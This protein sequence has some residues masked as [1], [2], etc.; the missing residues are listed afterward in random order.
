MMQIIVNCWTPE[1]YDAVNHAVIEVDKD[2]LEMLAKRLMIANRM[3]REDS[4]F[5]G[6]HYDCYDPTFINV[7]PETLGMT[8]EQVEDLSNGW[9][10][11]PAKMDGCEWDYVAMRPRI[12]VVMAGDVEHHRLDG[13]V[14]DCRIYWY[15]YDKH[16]GAESRTETSALELTDLLEIAKKLGAG[17]LEGVCG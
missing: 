8:E 5:M 2:L 9:S 13:R 12:L 4:E 17:Y 3:K 16:G 15:A 14:P 10:F 11:L 1:W 6:L 7:D